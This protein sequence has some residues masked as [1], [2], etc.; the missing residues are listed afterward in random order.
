LGFDTDAEPSPL[1]ADET[2]TY[3]VVC[4]EM[5][6]IEIRLPLNRLAGP[7]AVSELSPMLTG[8]SY[9]SKNGV[10]CW[11]PGPG[12]VGLYRFQVVVLDK[13][14][15]TSYRQLNINI[16][17]KGKNKNTLEVFKHETQNHR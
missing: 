6:P 12:F 4:E 14:G 16:Q 8:I 3:T 11:L 1:R 7:G 9:D 15:E 13:N 2:G 5:Q 17:P 10:F